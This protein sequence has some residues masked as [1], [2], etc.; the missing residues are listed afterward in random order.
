MED[1]RILKKII[2]EKTHFS[3]DSLVKSIYFYNTT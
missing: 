2:F 3:L 1:K